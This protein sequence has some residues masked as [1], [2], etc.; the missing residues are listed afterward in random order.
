MKLT[1]ID[2]TR[3]NT[4]PTDGLVDLN[5]ML[6]VPYLYTIYVIGQANLAWTGY[7]KMITKIHHE[8]SA[9]FLKGDDPL[10]PMIYTIIWWKRI[11]WRTFNLGTW[12]SD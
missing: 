5:I 10:F 3:N 8:E 2:T 1:R 11:G 6:A 9:C 7:Q 4:L 12:W